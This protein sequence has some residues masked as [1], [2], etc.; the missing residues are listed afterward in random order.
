VP[1]LLTVNGFVAS[2]GGSDRL[3]GIIG[4]EDP[5]DLMPGK[6]DAAEAEL[7]RDLGP[8]GYPASAWSAA[9]DSTKELLSTWGYAIAAGYL[10]SRMPELPEGLKDADKSARARLGEIRSGRA[11]LPGVVRIGRTA[12]RILTSGARTD[13]AQVP[14]ALFDHMRNG[15]A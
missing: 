2:I 9:P 14:G 1:V 6:L 11:S 15:R 3:A 12:P 7:E 13:G 5:D 4:S 8:V 10:A